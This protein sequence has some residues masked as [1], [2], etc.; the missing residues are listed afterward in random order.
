MACA[1]APIPRRRFNGASCMAIFGG[2]STVA[3]ADR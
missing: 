2:A 3:I 1:G